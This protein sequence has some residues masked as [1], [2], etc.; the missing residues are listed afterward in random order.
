MYIVVAITQEAVPGCEERVVVVYG[1][2]GGPDEEWRPQTARTTPV[3]HA[4]TLCASH[5]AFLNNYPQPASPQRL[6]PTPLPLNVS[7]PFRQCLF[8]IVSRIF[9]GDDEN[10]PAPDP[11]QSQHTR[12]LISNSQIGA[13]CPADK[14]HS[15]C[16]TC[17]AR[18]L[19]DSSAS[20]P[21]GARNHPPLFRL[22]PRQGRLHRPQHPRLH[23]RLYA[24]HGG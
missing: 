6:T 22:P 21:A 7:G 13:F 4:R 23:G 20:S 14:I 8:R 12:L 5:R 1:E 2:E 19:A 9:E 18:L 17:C 15:T 10:G 16:Q 24:R 3:T 11:R